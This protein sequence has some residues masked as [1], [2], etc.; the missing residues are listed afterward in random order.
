MLPAGAPQQ[1]K[2]LGAGQAKHEETVHEEVEEVE[3]EK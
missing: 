1:N 3:E 2:Q